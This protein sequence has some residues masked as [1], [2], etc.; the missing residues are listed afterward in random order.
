[1][2]AIY[3]DPTTRTIE[4][5]DCKG[6]IYDMYRL[7]EINCVTVVH[8]T[9]KDDLWLDDEGLLKQGD[10]DY[11]LWAHEDGAEAGLYVYAGKG[12]ILGHTPDGDTADCCMSIEAVQHRLRWLDRD[13]GQAAA[14]QILS[15]P[16]QIMSFDTW[17]EMDAYLNRR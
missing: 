12:L 2:K 1:M 3:I 6:D 11:F 10:Q 8:V 9:A 14:E 5:I 4:Q 7:L 15:Y 13:D 16:P 17:E